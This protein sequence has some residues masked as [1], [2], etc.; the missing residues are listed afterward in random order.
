MN[1]LRLTRHQ[2][3]PSQHTELVRIYGKNLT[4]LTVITISET[5]P[6]AGRVMELVDEHKADVLEAV[7]PLPLLADVLFRG[8]VPIIR[9]VMNR[10]IQDDGNIEFTFDHY[11]RLH[12]VVVETERL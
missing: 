2:L 12:R 7:L 11:E 9:A 4:H 1:I 5:V 6:N 3:T 10:V 8:T